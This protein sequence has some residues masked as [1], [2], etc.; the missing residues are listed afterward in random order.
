[1]PYTPQFSARATVS[2]RRLAWALGT[3]MTKTVDRV[4]DMIPDMV[5]SEMVCNKCRDQ[6]R[7]R[8]CAF[9]KKKKARELEKMF[10]L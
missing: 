2:I 4:I 5:D 6:V 3:H 10:G 8:E 7:C 9:G 1:M